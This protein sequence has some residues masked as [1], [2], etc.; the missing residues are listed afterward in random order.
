MTAEDLKKSILQQAIQGKLVPQ[1]PDDEPASTLLDRIREEKSRLVAEG[2]IKRDKNES[3]IYRTDDGRYIERINKTETDISAQIPFEIPDNWQWVRLGNIVQIRGGKR[4]PAGRKLTTENTGQIYIRVSDMKGYSIADNDLHYVPMD[5]QSQISSYVISQEDVYITVAG[6]IGRVGLVPK[7]F[8]GANLTENAD[9]LTLFIGNKHLLVYFLDSPFIQNQI[10]DLTT[11]VGQP[12][13]AIQ[14]IYNLLIPFPPQAEQERIAAKIEKLMPMVE[15]Y[16]KAQTRLDELN[17]SLGDNLCKSVLQY[18]IQGKLVP[19][20]P[21][22]EPACIL[23][24]CIREEKA[25]LISEGKIKRDKK[26]SEICRTD[27][28]RYIER[29]G[30]TETDITD[31]ILFD[32]PDSWAWTKIGDIF[33]HNNGKQLNKNNSSGQMMDYITTSNLYWDGFK[34]DNLKQMPFETTEIERCQAIKGDLLVCEGGDVGRSCIWN[35]DYPIMLQNHIHKLRGIIPVETKYFYYVLY[36]YNLMGIIGGK[37]IGIQ[38][39]SGK[40]L[41]NTLIPLPPLAEQK[42]IVERIEQIFSLCK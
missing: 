39:F 37:G 4:I 11:Q 20:N 40:A 16:D 38:G 26:E 23:L 24:D 15:E 13:L 27:D 35:F 12:K 22:E 32:I 7:L 1:N 31:K 28:G 41:H 10:K 42:R 29:I 33:F 19:Q 8:D 25:R 3:I 36:L 21:D 2:K 34:L 18:A 9:K 30:K 14:R 17:S 5:I 6:T